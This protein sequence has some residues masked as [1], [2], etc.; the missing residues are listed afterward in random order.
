[1]PVSGCAAFSFAW[2]P[3]AV[4]IYPAD[5]PSV[6]I[7]FLCSRCLSYCIYSK[8]IPYRSP[9]FH[10]KTLFFI[11]LRNKVFYKG[12]EHINSF[13]MRSLQTMLSNGLY[14]RIVFFDSVI[15]S[16]LALPPVFIL[17]SLL[18]L[19]CMILL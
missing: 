3:F 12:R 10:I 5:Y 8:S 13:L 9:F 15:L 2:P 14:L 17:E 1:M 11:K 18:D 4:A 16:T 19:F 7:A 6:F